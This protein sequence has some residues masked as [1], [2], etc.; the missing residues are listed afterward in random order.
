[1]TEPNAASPAP[2][3]DA[4]IARGPIAG[5]ILRWLAIHDPGGIDTTR[6]LQLAVAFVIVISLAYGTSR[7]FGLGLDVSFPLM[8]GAAALVLIT[9]T[10]AASR[11]AEA[12]TM[13]RI[14]ALAMGFLLV[15]LAVGPGEG[16]ANE[17]VQK[18]ILVP[19][20]FLALV[21]RRYGMD[22]QRLGLSLILVAT[23]GTILAPTRAQAL[24]F[25]LAFCQGAAVMVAL[26]LSPWRPSAV[27]AFI[28][29]AHDVQDMLAAYLRDMSEAVRA[30]RPFPA[31][32]GPLVGAAR[33]RVWN[34][35]ANASAEDPGGR[36]DFERLRAKIYR[37][38]VAVLLLASCIPAT[39]RNTPDWRG[40]FAAATDHIA[41]RLEALD[42]VDENAEERFERALEDL[43]Q[44]AFDAR[45]EP[46]ARF[47]LLRAVTAFERLSLLV[48]GI[49]AQ[50]TAPFPLP[51][52]DADGDLPPSPAP[53]ALIVT[54]PDGRRALSAPLK[55]ACQGLVATALTTALDLIFHLEHAYWATMTVM[56]VL[57]NSVGE[58]YMRVRY[59][60]VGTIIGVVL[61]MGLFLVLDQHIWLLAALCVLAQMIAIV[62]QKDRYDVASAA[63]G[64]SVIL[65]LHIIA[66]LGPQGMIAR[67]YET[68]IGAG[69]ALVVSYA[70]LPVYL[71]DELR[72]EVRALL[73]RGR[74]CFASWWPKAGPQ[75]GARVSMAP[76]AREVRMLDLRVPQLGAEQVFGHSAGDV[77]N[78]ASTLDVLMTYLALLEDV[79]QRLDQAAPKEEVVALA[80]A[81]RSRTL[82]AFAQALGEGRPA[83]E[84][85]AAPAVEAAVSMVLALADD[86]QVKQ[87]LPL[88]ADYLAYSDT[89][90]RPITELRIALSDQAPWN[91]TAALAVGQG[92]AQGAKP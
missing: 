57:G 12:R 27:K 74:D 44:A 5:R 62:T 3:T 80:E 39:S 11:R 52:A 55:V 77:V 37:L 79:T 78:I 75:G 64:F 28:T 45:L 31:D 23:V 48:T 51:H 59:R 18:L 50:E 10:P 49:A 16:P 4:P 6:A 65:G 60:T 41:R 87:V 88:V 61:G 30:G 90:R 20:S 63:V 53:P 33:A 24:Y 1:M 22:G 86:P 42:R 21:L 38:R 35:L 47:V 13:G 7:A 76:L 25:L 19:L 56:F 54:G 17:M 66:G 32:L 2:G 34:A 68:V 15:L 91:R 70:V 9:F 69:I 82:D 81:A 89:V 73:R 83:G 58:T 43:R 67:V 71:T 36:M 46:A 85:A 84:A 26:R 8:T 40:A 92:Q 72:P 14:F 29:S